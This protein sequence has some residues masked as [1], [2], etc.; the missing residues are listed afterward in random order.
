MY[1]YLKELKLK[2][3]AAVF[4]AITF[5][6]SSYLLVWLELNT[7][8]HAALWLPL[9]LW[10]LHKGTNKKRYYLITII[11]L[12]SSLLAGHVQTSLYLVIFTSIYYFHLHPITAS[13]FSLKKLSPLILILL[14]TLILTGIQYLPALILLK[15]SPRANS[16]PKIFSQFLLPPK[17]LVTL[18]APD[19][20]GNPATGNFW[21]RDYGEFAIYFGLAATILAISAIL[22]RKKSPAQKLYTYVFLLTLLFALNEPFSYIPSLLK[23]PILSSSAPARLLFLTQFA[24]AVLAAIGYQQFS[25]HPDTVKRS[26]KLIGGTLI[27]IWIV[28]LIHF[29]LNKD[30]VIA[31]Q[32]KVSLKNLIVPTCLLFG[33]VLTWFTKKKLA[34]KHRNFVHLLVFANLLISVSYFGY[35]YLPFSDM[36]F[37]FPS[38]PPL[39]FL[40]KTAGNFRI[41]GDYTASITSNLWTP[42]HLNSL[43]G[44]DSL[45]ISRYGELLAAAANLGVPAASIPRSDA[46]LEPNHD[47]FF[48]RRLQDVLGV[49][50]L[51]D[52]N[53]FPKS[54][55]EPDLN[56]F[57]PGRYQLIW[58]HDKFKIYENLQSQPRA[59]LV[60]SFQVLKTDQ[61]LLARFFESSWDPSKQVLLETDPA[62][63]YPD[64]SKSSEAAVTTFPSWVNIDI[65]TPNVVSMKV[66]TPIPQFLFLSDEYYPD[67]QATIDNKPLPIMRANY[68][69]RAVLVPPGTHQVVFSYHFLH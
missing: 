1:L 52:K 51:F 21:S 44:Y 5:A 64:Y 25:N 19:Y 66:S 24:G 13:K 7:V 68:A 38:S 15:H 39:E 67:W 14:T 56:R 20:F 11:S 9:A 48:R 50:Y 55:W 6:F 2:L 31:A 22:T 30:S 8:G 3:P 37:T 26:L 17:Q 62:F 23:I 28:T 36:E 16:D 42:Y 59:F 33:F 4:G 12:V 45:Y 29:G 58:Q 53:D 65:Y 40:S 43:E 57:P 10:S 32:T 60:P 61:E 69:F 41:F 27:I 35:K 18:L 49:K 54:A 46:N 63:V 34:V 47:D